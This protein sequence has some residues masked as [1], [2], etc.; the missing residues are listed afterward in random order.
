M[1]NSALIFLALSFIFVSCS[2]NDNDDLPEEEVA[3]FYAL[4]V[5]NSWNYQYY[6]KDFQTNTFVPMDAFDEVE[7]VGTAQINNK[8]YYELQTTASGTDNPPCQPEVG[9]TSVFVRDSLGYLINDVG[10]IYNTYSN[11]EEEYL[12]SNGTS[13]DIYAFLVSGTFDISVPAGT[14]STLLNEKFA[15]DEQ[16]T[17]LP[18]RDMTHYTDGVGQI[19][20]T[21]SAIGDPEHRW[22]K[23]LISY[24]IN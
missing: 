24:E 2:N 11:P 23:R 22:E 3:N 20:Q 12:V 21:Y 19:R 13:F 15:K 18:G 5:G 16:G 10:Y 14:F 7:V 1:K 8:T 6:E 4:T 17:V 9:V